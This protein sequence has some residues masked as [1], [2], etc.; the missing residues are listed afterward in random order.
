MFS[1]AWNVKKGCGVAGVGN[2]DDQRPIALSDSGQ[3]IEAGSPV[4]PHISDP[5][6]VLQVNNGLVRR[7]ALQIV[8]SDQT[9]VFA[10][11]L[12]W[13]FQWLLGR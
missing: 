8:K 7:A 3:R 4:G 10:L 12:P 5:P 2:I 13:F 1:I 9:H 11:G 6:F